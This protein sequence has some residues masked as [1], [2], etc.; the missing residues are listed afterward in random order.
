MA[1]AAKQRRP[2][3]KAKRAIEGAKKAAKRNIEA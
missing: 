1:Y 2:E 3:I